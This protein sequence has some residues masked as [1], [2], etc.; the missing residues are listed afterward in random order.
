MVAVGAVQLHAVETGLTRSPRARRE[1]LHR[2]LYLHHRHP[3]ALE[4]VQRV[5][6][7]RRA[8]ALLVLDA[9]HITLA[10]GVAQLHDEPAVVLA[11]L[12]TE[13]VPERDPLV[14]VDRRV[15]RDDTTSNRHRHE[16]RDDRP[17]ASPGE[18]HLPVDPSLRT[19]PVVVVEP[20]RH[21]RAEDSVLDGEIAKRQRL[22][23]RIGHGSHPSVGRGP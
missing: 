18:L 21:V 15:V 4:P 7:V 14:G 11:D 5:A 10:T 8:Q 9:R 19:G 16:R 3:L 17:H 23:N 6:L 12:H 2:L 22:E 20:A 1:R 13:L